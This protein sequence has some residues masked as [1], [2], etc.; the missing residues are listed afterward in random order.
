MIASVREGRVPESL[1]KEF[2]PTRRDDPEQMTKVPYQPDGK[3]AMVDGACLLGCK[4]RKYYC[5]TVH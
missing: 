4:L 3:C 5:R 2:E 1:A